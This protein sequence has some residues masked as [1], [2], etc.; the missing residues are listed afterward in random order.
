MSDLLKVRVGGSDYLCKWE[1][2]IIYK[3]NF[4]SVDSAEVY[5]GNASYNNL[6]VDDK[7]VLFNGYNASF[8]QNFLNNTN[9]LRYKIKFEKMTTDVSKTNTGQFCGQWRLISFNYVRY[10]DNLPRTILQIYNVDNLTYY[11]DYRMSSH[12]GGPYYTYYLLQN[13]APQPF[14]WETWEANIDYE[15]MTGF[16]LLNGIK[17]CDYT[18]KDKSIKLSTGNWYDAKYEGIDGIPHYVR[19]V[20]VEAY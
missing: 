17:V 15:N 8:R 18:L 14:V 6:L 10:G 20:L 19:N 13:N 11:G 16:I 12:D 9:K 3:N 2:S 5:S 4:T 7:G 1:P